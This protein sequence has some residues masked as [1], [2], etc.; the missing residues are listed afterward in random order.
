MKHAVQ[1]TILGQQYVVKSAAH[2]EEVRKVAAFVNSQIAE[3][4]SAS[5]TADTL[6]TVVLALLNVSGAYLRLQGQGP[7]HDAQTEERIRHLLAR[8]ERV[9]PDPAE[10]T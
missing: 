2:P 5:K 4:A 6:N 7:A 8:L 10:E 3:I 1:V 9:C